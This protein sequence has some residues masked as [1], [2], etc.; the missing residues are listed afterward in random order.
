MSVTT[1]S[2]VMKTQNV[3]ILLA[4]IAANVEK[5]TMEMKSFVFWASVSS[6]IVRIISNVSRRQLLHVNVKKAFPIIVRP[7]VLISMNVKLKW[8]VVMS[9][10]IA[11]IQ[12]EA[13]LAVELRRRFSI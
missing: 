13:L 7:F 6:R 1:Q 8:K 12:S 10:Q 4:V 3:P 2:Y 9:I 5:G 11:P